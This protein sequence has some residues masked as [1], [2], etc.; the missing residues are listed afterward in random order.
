VDFANK[1]IISVGKEIK[2]ARTRLRHRLA[3]A[4][5]YTD[6]AA[7]EFE[8]T[9]EFAYYFGDRRTA[10]Q[11]RLIRSEED[12]NASIVP[13]CPLV[14]RGQRAPADCQHYAD[15]L[16]LRQ[17]GWTMSLVVTDG[18]A[19]YPVEIHA[20][21]NIAEERIICVNGSGTL[22]IE[23]I[24]YHIDHSPE[25]YVVPSGQVHW[26]RFDRPTRFVSAFAVLPI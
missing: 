3:T 4:F 9:E 7:P 12:L 8:I 23:G 26:F 14:L 22:W 11:T 1:G 16:Y 24:P 20:H 19:K 25:P 18:E 5:E 6:L 15:A 21:H 17:E 13:F 10:T 2:E